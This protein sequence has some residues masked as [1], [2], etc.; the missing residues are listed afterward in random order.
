M[1]T[2]FE[3]WAD[4]RAK[5]LTVLPASS[6]YSTSAPPSS[7]P[8][9]MRRKSILSGVVHR[10]IKGVGFIFR[11]GSVDRLTNI[12]GLDIL[13]A[14]KYISDR[15]RGERAAAATTEGADAASSGAAAEGGIDTASLETLTLGFCD[16][17][18]KVYRPIIPIPLTD[19][20]FLW[21][22]HDCG[23]CSV[24]GKCWVEDCPHYFCQ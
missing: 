4:G 20:C 21:L 17:A 14:L 6:I 9:S 16:F 7:T 3:P 24:A 8:F 13:L 1:S 19:R 10:R 5:T 18:E 12:K 23:L 11:S 22:Y 2:V 15:Q